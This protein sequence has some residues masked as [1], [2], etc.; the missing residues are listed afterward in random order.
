MLN[1]LSARKALF[2]LPWP[3]TENMPWPV[4]NFAFLLKAYLGVV[5]TCAMT[6]ARFDLRFDLR[7]G[8]FVI[9]SAQGNALSCMTQAPIRRSNRRS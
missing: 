9:M 8:A 6:C 3:D 5:S 1:A 4:N 2:T 7:F